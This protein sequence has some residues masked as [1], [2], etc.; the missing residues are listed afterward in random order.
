MEK[1]QH[2]RQKLYKNKGKDQE[3]CRYSDH[4]SGLKGKN[5]ETT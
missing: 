4:F 5:Q 2:G 1:D 3:V